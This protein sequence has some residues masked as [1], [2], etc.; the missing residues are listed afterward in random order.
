[1]LQNPRLWRVGLGVLSTG[2][3][4]VALQ[5]PL[6][7]ETWPAPHGAATP[8][9]ALSHT[10]VQV[11][12]ASSGVP[13]D[14][15]AYRELVVD[16]YCVRCHNDRMKVAN[17]SLAGIDL[18]NASGDAA[19]GRELE[20]VVLKLRA[21]AMP[22]NGSPRPDAATME[23]FVTALEASLDRSAIERPNPGRKET[24]HRL[25]RAE[26]KNAVRDV[27]GLDID[28]S[29]LV[30]SD[31]S[32]Y[33]FDNIAGVV[34]LS[35][36]LVERY[37]VA[38][39]KIARV[40]VGSPAIQYS[41][42]ETLLTSET[43]QNQRLAGLP[44]GSR[45]GT[46]IRHWF[47]LDA[48]Y[49]IAIDLLEGTYS[50][51][52]ASRVGFNEPHTVEVSVDGDRVFEHTFPVR[53]Q[54]VRQRGGGFTMDRDT[55]TALTVKV[56]IKAGPH[57]I[58]VTFPKKSSALS[59]FARN[60][61][62]V[63]FY[64]SGAGEGSGGVPGTS[65]RPALGTVRIAGPF[66]PT[67]PGDTPSRRRIFTC[68]PSASLTEGA[69][70]NQILTR[71]AR[72][73]YR[74]PI[75]GSDL[76]PLLELF[77]RGK[78]E[79]GGSFERGIELAVQRILVSPQFLF[80]IEREPQLQATSRVYRIPDVDLAS[81]LSFFLWSSV[82]DE[83]LLTIAER[84]TLQ[85]PE[86][87]REQVRR[88]LADPKAE[89]FIQNF[90]GQWLM[91]R[92]L[93][94]TSVDL[95]EFPDFEGSLRLAYKRET[96]LFF[97]DVLRNPNA[98]AMQLLD[99]DFTYLNEQLAR[100]YGVPG[101]AGEEF[102]RVPVIAGSRRPGGLLGQGSVLMGTSYANR[103]SP[104]IRGKFILSTFLGTPPP[105]PPPNIP[106]LEENKIGVET[107][108]LSVRERLAAHR[109]SPACSGCHNVMDPLGLALE[110][111]DAVGRWRD[112]EEGGAPIDSTVMLFDGTELKSPTDLRNALV[113][114]RENVL[115]TITE[116]LMTYALGRGVDYYDYPAIRR[117]VR[118]AKAQSLES[119]ILG[120]VLSEPFQYRRAE[121]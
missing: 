19:V 70:A 60:W 6:A 37:S 69:C 90:T 102:R 25:N 77:A 8:V 32:S 26:Y 2:A 98:S 63:P 3:Y 31:A 100:H 68:T 38:A 50:N 66:N 17:L 106:A 16:K 1:M 34:K 24:F 12:A 116:R 15:S 115:R 87:L 7:S 40:A 45:G 65:Y 97:T 64:G 67:G 14:I 71:V 75:T 22:P 57:D 84:G 33:G 76:G 43:D 80:R 74:R 107:K 103:T 114:R 72:A 49:E 46:L 78:R 86:V 58:V 108:V 105:E 93:P 42:A 110:N 39:E 92:N 36:A 47:P 9:P 20:K 11:A 54:A 119:L 4:L 113:L 83:A 52:T 56:P 5:L 89:A 55:E 41:V 51:R 61:F 28:V 111:F 99:A 73:A 79:G 23:G 109:K 118:D 117:I 48:E 27:L 13:E 53:N 82:P 104:T 29:G 62:A 35:N 101:V 59:T 120:I 112:K 30:P 91:L 18:T 95:G 96:E 81:R 10:F 21:Q 88:M 94:G 121:S 44:L 85:R